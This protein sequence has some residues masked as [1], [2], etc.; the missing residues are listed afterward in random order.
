MF[1]MALIFLITPMLFD[2][3]FE[4]V[5]MEGDNNI[6]DDNNHVQ[7]TSGGN[8]VDGMHNFVSFPAAGLQIVSGRDQLDAP[9]MTENMHEERLNAVEALGSSFM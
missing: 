8:E 4:N 1:Y 9:L 6:K 2:A 3:H 7:T 5:K